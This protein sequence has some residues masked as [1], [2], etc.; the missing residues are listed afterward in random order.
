[1]I[2]AEES[3]ALEMEPALMP[4]RTTQDVEVRLRLDR[5][6]PR[7]LVS[8]D[9]RTLAVNLVLEENAE[10]VHE[11]L[12]SQARALASP[13]GGAVS[14]VPVFRVET[15]GRTRSEIL[16]FAPFTGLVLLV[17]LWAIYRS[18]AVAISCLL[19]GV[20][21]AFAMLSAMGYLESPLTITTIILP[22]VVLALGCAYSMHLILPARMADRGA[23]I[24]AI[25]PSA[26]P[27]ALSGLTTAVGFG[28][29]GLVKIDAV[30][31]V[32]GFGGLGVL[33]VSAAALTLV[34]AC[35]SFLSPVCRRPAGSG[36]L[37]TVLPRLLGQLASNRASIGAWLLL[38]PLIAA[39][40][41]AIRVETDATQW[42][43]PGNPVRDDYDAIRELLSG[44][45][46]INFVVNAPAEAS[47]VGQDP[48]E[49]IDALARHLEAREDVGKVLSIADPLRQIHGG[50]L[51]DESQPLPDSDALVEQYLVVLDSLERLSDLVTADRKHANIVIRANNNGSHHLRKIAE[52]ADRWWETNGPAGF[53][54][55]TTG[56]MFEY[57]RAED[58]IAMGQL[59]G[60]AFAV[61]AIGIILLAIFRWPRLALVSLAPNVLPVA[62]VFGAMGAL[63]VPLDAGTVLVGSLALGIAVDDTVHVM[64][65]FVERTD[66]G[67]RLRDAV[68]T[69]LAE[70]LPAVVY[71][72]AVVSLSFLILGLSE[73]TFTRNLGLLTA[74]ILVLCLVADATLLPALL[75]RLPRRKAAEKQAS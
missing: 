63:Q 35:L 44:I 13:L 32:G 54:G 61:A 14:G 24:S 10:G 18:V 56:I 59:R 12:V 64:T 15:N 45:S 5:V 23:V 6:A 2:H 71:S 11:A 74:A 8:A 16:F 47:V 58:E 41:T 50:F 39:G 42:L 73:F 62:G 66:N 27:I 40:V 75:V 48:L 33:V 68:Q 60:L 26:L 70:A 4:G 21:G 34:P 43:P 19:P 46:P 31:F 65:R 38:V 67:D 28:A 55:K 3:G 52:E 7:S 51:G 30:R 72:T 49:A 17:V 37:T 22:S 1:M 9:N 69:A 29:I 57:A 36:W 53:K 25:T 20:V